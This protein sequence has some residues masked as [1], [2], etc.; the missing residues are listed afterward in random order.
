MTGAGGWR[1]V[2]STRTGASSAI[3]LETPF[4]VSHRSGEDVMPQFQ[5]LPFSHH[6]RGAYVYQAMP[7]APSVRAAKLVA[8][9]SSSVGKRF[10]RQ[11]SKYCRIG[12]TDFA[13]PSANRRLSA[14]IPR[15]SKMTSATQFDAS[16]GVSRKIG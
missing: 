4:I 14:R 11:P 8:Q 2:G 3:Q 16:S 5:H 13:R 15:I 12:Q 7:L 9:S 10:H 6:V 1:G